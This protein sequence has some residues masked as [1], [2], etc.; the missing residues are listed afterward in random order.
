MLLRSR[1]DMI[2]GFPLRK[3]QTSSPRYDG[4]LQNN[5]PLTRHH[6]CYSGFHRYKAPLLPR[7]RGRKIILILL[8]KVKYYVLFL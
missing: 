1:P 8:R 5:L 3:T 7:L 4:L 2:R 6:P